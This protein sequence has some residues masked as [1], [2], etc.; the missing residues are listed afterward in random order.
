MAQITNIVYQ[1]LDQEYGER[2]D[3]FM[4][5]PVDSANLIAGHGIEGDQKAGHNPNRQ[6]NILSQSWLEKV[7]SKGYNIEPGHFGE[8]M[9]VDG[10]DLEDLEKGVRLQLG[11]EAVVE[12]TKSRTGCERVEMVQGLSNDM[13]EGDVGMLVKVITGGKVQV[14][15]QVI[16]LEKVASD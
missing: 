16:I 7:K 4:R 6:I 15:D 9:R 2:L 11:A 10:L 13:L 8:Q 5:V 1:P 14:G 12:I 3:Y